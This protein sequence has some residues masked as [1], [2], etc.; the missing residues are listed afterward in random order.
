MQRKSRVEI[1]KIEK[2][3][4]T[5]Y[6]HYAKY[7]WPIHAERGGHFPSFDFH[8]RKN[9]VQRCTFIELLPLV[10]TVLYSPFTYFIIAVHKE[11]KEINQI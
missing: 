11:R 10:F 9:I 6:H 8:P 2:K 1:Q 3:K 5:M 4:N 7:R